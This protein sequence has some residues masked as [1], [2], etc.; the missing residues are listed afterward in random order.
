MGTLMVYGIVGGPLL[1]FAFYFIIKDH[2]DKRKEQQEN[3]KKAKKEAEVLGDARQ[4]ELL[5]ILDGVSADYIKNQSL[6]TNKMPSEIIS[7]MVR[8]RIAASA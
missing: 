2:I 5:D 8:E 6:S 7:E 1:L 4:K 3:L